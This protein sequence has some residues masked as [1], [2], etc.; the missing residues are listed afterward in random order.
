MSTCNVQVYTYIFYIIKQDIRIY[1]YILRIAGQT[2]GPIR[3]KSFVDTHGYK[4]M[5]INIIYRDGRMSD[6]MYCTSICT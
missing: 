1:I 3:L 2:A 5:Y 4:Y 6:Y